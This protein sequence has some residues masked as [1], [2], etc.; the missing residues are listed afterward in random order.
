MS[1]RAYHRPISI[2]VE[3]IQ[4]MPDIKQLPS[5][6]QMTVNLKFDHDGAKQMVLYLLNELLVK[7]PLDYVFVEITGPSP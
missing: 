2:R 4:R 7:E 3:K 5:E 6:T 1:G